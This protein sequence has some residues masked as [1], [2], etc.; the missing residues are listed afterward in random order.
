MPIESILHDKY[1]TYESDIWPVGVI[2]LQFILRKYNIFNNIKMVSKP[3]Q[4]KNT[5]F[6]YYLMEVA[7]LLGK[8]VVEKRCAEMGYLVQLPAHLQSVRIR[9]IAMM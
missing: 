3:D 2:L 4:I 9:D 6:I 7:T 8:E 5:Y 1:Q